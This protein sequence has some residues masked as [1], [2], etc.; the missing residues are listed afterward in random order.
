MFC[1]LGACRHIT[2]SINLRPLLVA[3]C[4]YLLGMLF[5]FSDTLFLSL[6]DINMRLKYIFLRLFYPISE[7]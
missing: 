6:S 7:L 3:A 4:I 5:F 2:S 1:N